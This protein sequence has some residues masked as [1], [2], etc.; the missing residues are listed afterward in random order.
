M[1]DD[2][3]GSHYAGAAEAEAE[4][5]SKPVVTIP[6][7]VLPGNFAGVKWNSCCHQHRAALDAAGIPWRAD[8]DAG[9]QWIPVSER[10]PPPGIDVLVSVDGWLDIGY[11]AVEDYELGWHWELRESL[12]DDSKVTHWIPAPEGPVS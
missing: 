1:T 2:P 6:A 9:S 10:L 8:G 12:E 7:T 11:V 3:G 4:C 5:G